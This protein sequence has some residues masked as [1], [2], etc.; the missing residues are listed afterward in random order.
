MEKAPTLSEQFSTIAETAADAAYQHPQ[1][2]QEQEML[3]E[4]PTKNQIAE[5]KHETK[6]PASGRK[7]PQHKNNT[8]AGF[9][10]KGAQP[11]RITGTPNLQSRI[12]IA[13]RSPNSG[14][15]L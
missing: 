12:R 6:S 11:K 15:R 9:L 13:R 4:D 8:P 14:A 2:Q 3:A 7:A 1:S 5:V 10:P